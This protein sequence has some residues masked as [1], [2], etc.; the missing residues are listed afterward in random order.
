LPHNSA[1][2]KSGAPTEQFGGAKHHKPKS[3]RREVKKDALV[4]IDTLGMMTP[5]GIGLGAM[6]EPSRERVLLKEFDVPQKQKRSTR[7]PQCILVATLAGLVPPALGQTETI[8]VA[9]NTASSISRITLAGDVST[10]FSGYYTGT[11]RDPRGLALDRCGNLFVAD[12]VDSKIVKIAP[13]GDASVFTAFANGMGITGPQGMAFDPTGNLC[14]VTGG[15]QVY[16]YSP[17]GVGGVWCSTSSRGIAF[18]SAGFGYAVQGQNGIVQIAANGHATLWGGSPIDF[19]SPR[20]LAVDRIGSV[21]LADTTASTIY[22]FSPTIGGIVFTQGHNLANPEYLG[23]D[24]AGY[25][26]VTDSFQNAVLKFAPDGSNTVFVSTGLNSPRG[27]AIGVMC[28]ANCDGSTTP[29][30][31]NANDF[32]CFLNAFAAG[33]DYANCDGSTTP[34]ILNANDFACFLN[35]FSAG[36]S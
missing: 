28:D 20:G 18:D 22:E 6:H 12:S 33:R 16:R 30:I 4:K 1:A 32:T 5:M 31:L 36:C 17:D 24:S 25:L 19:V 3:P 23:F 8:F 11:F 14:A 35:K 15:G 9:N 10:Y 26:Y 29:P 13:N 27:I 2:A 21:Y 34:P 7:N